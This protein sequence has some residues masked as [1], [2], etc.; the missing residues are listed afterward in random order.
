MVGTSASTVLGV[1]LV[2]EIL[3]QLSAVVAIAKPGEGVPQLP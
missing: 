2:H 3:A 1:R